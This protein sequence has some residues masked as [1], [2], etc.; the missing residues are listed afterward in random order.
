MINAPTHTSSPVDDL[1]NERTNALV[2]TE[3]K[4][5]HSGRLAACPEKRTVIVSRWQGMTEGEH[6]LTADALDKHYTIEILLAESRVDCFKNGSQISAL[7]GGFGATQIAAP[8]EN[9]QCRFT[10]KMRAIH[11]F[12]PARTVVDMYEAVEQRSCPKDFQLTD[13]AF[14][15]DHKL[16]R[17]ASVGAD[18]DTE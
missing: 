3:T 2:E 14:R 13:P 18:V 6:C 7:A 11:L 4:W 8:G 17:L 10:R 5:R 15:V 12:V 9:I 1:I 16:A